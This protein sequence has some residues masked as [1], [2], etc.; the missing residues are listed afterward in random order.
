MRNDSLTG[1]SR[2]LFRTNRVRHVDGA[3]GRLESRANREIN[4]RKL[5]MS[6]AIEP[7]LKTDHE[8][9]RRR[10]IQHHADRQ[11]T[12]GY[13]ARSLVPRTRREIAPLIGG[14]AGGSG[15]ARQCAGSG[16]KA[17][18]PIRKPVFPCAQSDDVQTTYACG[19]SLCTSYFDKRFGSTW[20]GAY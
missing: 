4:T 1:C 11:C 5:S 9:P 16:R 18:A 6:G 10:T 15:P 12:L 13:G 19:I 3:G 8:S 20:G 2:S 17:A 14:D 7:S